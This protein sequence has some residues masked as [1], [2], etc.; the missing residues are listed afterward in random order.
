MI[1]SENFYGVKCDRCGTLHTNYDYHS[2]F[3]D[4]GTAENEATDAGWW[5]EDG[6]CYCTNCYEQLDNDD[7]IIKDN[8]PLWF[9]Q[10]KNYIINIMI[11]HDNVEWQE[12]DDYIMFGGTW[13][14]NQKVLEDCHTKI[15]QN[16]AGKNN[17]VINTIGNQFKVIISKK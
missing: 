2:F 8:L 15:L 3:M 9:H 16:Y 1:V 10:V 5:F 14:Y 7:I 13:K 4:A 17:L 6:K 11:G 12:N